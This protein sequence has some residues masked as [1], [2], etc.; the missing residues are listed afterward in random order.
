M[1]RKRRVL[2]TT[3][4]DGDIGKKIRMG[5]GLNYSTKGIRQPDV[6]STAVGEKLSKISVVIKITSWSKRTFLF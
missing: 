1:M 3:K 5:N 4:T 2:D 6:Y